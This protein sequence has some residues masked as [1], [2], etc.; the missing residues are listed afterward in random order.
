VRDFGELVERFFSSRFAL[1]SVGDNIDT[2]SAAGRLV[3]N[4]LTSVAQWEREATGERTRDALAH[5][6]LE[7]GRLGREGLGWRRTADT[8]SH[9]RRHVEGVVD[10]LA[11]IARV[12]HLRRS[13][14]TLTA[15]AATLTAERRRTK[16]GGNWTAESIRRILLR[17]ADSSPG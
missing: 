5:V 10:E 2:R 7:G 8:D 3:L 1:L 13:G 12:A 17:C 9:G 15:I 4:V 6:K 16:R 14:M 11:T